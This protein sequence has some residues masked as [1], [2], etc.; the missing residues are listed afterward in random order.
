MLCEQATG[1]PLKAATSDL[2][3][4][5]NQ[6]RSPATATVESGCREPINPAKQR[7][8]PLGRK[9]RPAQLSGSLDPHVVTDHHLR[10]MNA[11]QHR[12]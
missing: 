8:L 12:M 6:K 7:N 9:V 11:D 10:P 1:M 3:P 2:D 4:I 5:G